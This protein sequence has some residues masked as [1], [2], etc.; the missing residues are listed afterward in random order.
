MYIQVP[1]FFVSLACFPLLQFYHCRAVFI[2]CEL[3]WCSG[4]SD[5]AVGLMEPGSN[6]GWGKRFFSPLYKTSR[7]ALE[8]TQHPVQLVQSPPPWWLNWSRHECN[9]SP[10]SSAEVKNRWSHTYAPPI[11]L[12]G[13]NRENFTFFTSPITFVL[14]LIPLVLRACLWVCYLLQMV[15]VQLLC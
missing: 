4:Y 15:V 11:C 10:P 3:E 8:P 7:L 13:R 9:Y 5:W 6:P 1:G 2:L 12:A 14:F